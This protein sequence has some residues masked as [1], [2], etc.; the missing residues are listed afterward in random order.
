[1]FEFHLFYERIC[2]I[3]EY[4]KSVCALKLINN[5]NKKR[6]KKSNKGEREQDMKGRERWEG[7]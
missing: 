6:I 5:M 4:Q 1:M 3:Q 2:K 7:F